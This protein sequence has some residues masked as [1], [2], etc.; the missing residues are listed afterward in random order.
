MLSLSS[1]KMAVQHRGRRCSTVGLGLVMTS[2]EALVSCREGRTEV[3]E[4]GSRFEKRS[5]GSGVVAALGTVFG[6]SLPLPPTW[7]R[8]AVSNLEGSLLA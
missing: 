4:R 6:L 3:A 5:A 7:R 1:G 2:Q 8:R